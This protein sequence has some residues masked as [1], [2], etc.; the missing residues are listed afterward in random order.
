MLKNIEMQKVAP[1]VKVEV[2]FF[3]ADD[4]GVVDNPDSLDSC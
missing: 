2:G 3:D 4:D 1:L